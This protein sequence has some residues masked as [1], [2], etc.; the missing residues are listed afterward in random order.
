MLHE[1]PSIFTLADVAAASSTNNWHSRLTP[2]F[3]KKRIVIDLTGADVIEPAFLVELARLGLY[4][5]GRRMPLGRLVVDSPYVR[6]AL[7]A[8]GFDRQWPLFRSL[9]E[10]IASFEE[11][12]RA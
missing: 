11:R 9:S 1:T 4:R 6:N 7:T 10:A 5:R 8:V 3:D 12:M 2:F